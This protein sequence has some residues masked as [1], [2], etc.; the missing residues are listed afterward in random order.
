MKKINYLLLMVLLTIPFLGARADSTGDL[1]NG[2]LTYTV[3]QTGGGHFAWYATTPRSNNE[4][5][6]QDNCMAATTLVLKCNEGC[7]LNNADIIALRN[8]LSSNTSLVSLS[9]YYAKFMTDLT[10]DNGTAY[11]N[12]YE[13]DEHTWPG[14]TSGQTA[15]SNYGSYTNSWSSTIYGYCISDELGAGMFAN[16]TNL[17]SVILPTSVTKIGTGAFC[18]CTNLR[19]VY[20]PSNITAFGWESFMGD[21]KLQLLVPYTEESG[22][23]ADLSHVTLVNSEA[24]KDC[25]LLPSSQFQSLTGVTTIG[26]RAFQNTQVNLTTVQQIISQFQH[27]N[28][29]PTDGGYEKI[30]YQAFSGCTQIKGSVDLTANTGGY[31][32]GI[33]NNAFENCTGMTGV[34]INSEVTSIG[35]YAFSGCSA[36]N[37]VHVHSGTAPTCPLN[38]FNG[39]TPNLCQVEFSDGA[40]NGTF[41]GTTAFVNGETTGYKT[42]YTQPGFLYLLTKTLD[43]NNTV[44]NCKVQ[45]HAIVNLTRTFKP[46]WNTIALPFGCPSYGTDGDCARQYVTALHTSNTTLNYNLGE[47]MIAAYRGFNVSHNTFRF[48]LYANVDTDPLDEFEPLLIYMPSNDIKLDNLYTFTDVNLNVDHNYT[49]DIVNGVETNCVAKEYNASEMLGIYNG[50]SR[51]K[52]YGNYDHNTT[53]FVNNTYDTYRFKGTFVKMTE[54]L[55]TKDYFIQNNNGTCCF[56]QIPEDN[57]A[58]SKAFRGWFAYDPVSGG[59]KSS[60]IP[61]EVFNEEGNTVTGIV[62]MAADGEQANSG[63]IYNLNGQLVRTNASSTDG[64]TRGIYV[65]NGKKVIVK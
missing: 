26:Y 34:N 17:E 32:K 65:I 9:L 59:A 64:L 1:V 7:Y 52:F 31:I 30:P 28:T 35:E 39:V 50:D 46:G 4:W 45:Y 48:L 44:Y 12:T 60:T 20:I 2:T 25:T 29:K 18:G 10:S 63:N 37:N 33:A 62:N 24:F 16:C 55:T 38:A 22:V 54:T 47:F 8:V 6:G 36:L 5:G 23:T 14:V 61:V 3:S 40:W 57:K 49:S 43:E 11:R 41:N 58:A 51:Y 27:G 15:T 21:N 19:S 13:D 56:Y 42:Y 53:P